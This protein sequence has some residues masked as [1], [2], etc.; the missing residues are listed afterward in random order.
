[1]LAIALLIALLQ[2]RL[3]RRPTAPL[4][5]DYC[6]PARPR[7]IS[8]SA[9]ALQVGQRAG[10]QDAYSARRRQ[11]RRYVTALMPAPAPDAAGVLRVTGTIPPAAAPLEL[12][13][14]WLSYQ[15]GEAPPGS[16]HFRDAWETIDHLLLGSGV[17]R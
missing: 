17:V 8:C 2:R 12:F 13:S 6:Q 16:Y 7:G 4:G 1:M 15:A 10:C 9:S 14:P 11:G 5:T 3:A